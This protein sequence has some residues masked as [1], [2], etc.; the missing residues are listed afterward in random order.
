MKINLTKKSMFL[1][2]LVLAMALPSTAMAVDCTG[3]P[4]WAL[5]DTYVAG[6]KAQQNDTLY[7]TK[8]WTN[9]ENPATAGEWGAWINLGAC[10]VV[11]PPNNAPTV[12]FTS[13]AEGSTIDQGS[14]V[15]FVVNAQDSDDR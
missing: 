2:P 12:A 8:W 9:L 14:T 6:A 5:G 11:E 3:V 15:D 10:D 1:K 7:E 4:E 13:P